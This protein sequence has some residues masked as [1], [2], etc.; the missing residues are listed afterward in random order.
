VRLGL[1]QKGA[2]NEFYRAEFSLGNGKSVANCGASRLSPNHKLL[3][4]FSG[5]QPLDNLADYDLEGDATVSFF[6]RQNEFPLKMGKLVR[7]AD[8]VVELTVLDPIEV[9]NEFKLWLGSICTPPRGNGP[10]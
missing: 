10:K 5:I 9:T 1:L 2:S 8:Y 3:F 4:L 6:Y 7:D